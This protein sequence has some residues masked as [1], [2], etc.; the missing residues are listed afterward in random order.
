MGLQAIEAA[1]K[2]GSSV[3]LV[4]QVTGDMTTAH[5]VVRQGVSFQREGTT[6]AFSPTHWLPG[7]KTVE[8]SRRTSRVVARGFVAVGVC[9]LSLFIGAVGNKGLCGEAN[10]RAQAFVAPTEKERKIVQ[11]NAMRAESSPVSRV[12][13]TTVVEQKQILE[14]GREKID[15]LADRLT[16][17]QRLD[18]PQG[19]AAQAPKSAPAWARK[20]ALEHEQEWDRAEVLAPALTSSLRGE[21]DAL[22]SAAEAARIK[23]RQALKQELKQERDKAEAV[24]RELTSLRADLDAARIAGPEAAKAAAAAV[25][26]QQALKQELKQERDKAEAVARELTSLRAD[27]DAARIA[28]PKAAKAAAAAVEQQQALKQ[29]LKQER[30]KAEAV[31]RE[32]TSLRADLDAARIAGPK[33]AKAAAAAVEQ[34]QALKQELKQE[35]D[36]AE[37]VSRELTSLRADLDAA[38]IA[39]PKAA[40]AAAAAVEQ[41]QALKQELKQERDKA[42]VVSRELTSLRAE[43][44]TARA[45]G[46]ETARTAEAVK[47][48]QKLAFGKERDKAETLARELASARKEAEERSARL[49]AAHAEVLQVIETS[50]ATAAEQKL[51]LAR[52]RDRADALARELTSVRNELEA[53]NRQIA[54][55]NALGALRS[56]EPVVDSAREWMAEHPSRTIAGKGRLPEQISGEAT[57]STSGRSSASKLPRP[58]AQLTAREAAPDSDPKVVMATE[59]S[60]S[61]GAASHSPV[62]EQRLLARANALLRQ[63]DIS[64]ARPLLEHALERG[65]ARAAFMLAETYDARVLQS[66]RARGISGDPTKARELY[67]RAQAGGIEDA[68]ERIE[69]LK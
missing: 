40:K 68:K 39:G 34:Q 11:P 15:I 23:Q 48:E 27:L 36:K 21:L 59:R 9:V 24:A 41:Q 55:L 47:I 31:A 67:A 56:R 42:E 17:I 49:A 22:R 20:Q 5:W 54:A 38:R 14:L 6:I 57:A 50:S 66:W 35:R 62:D 51:A 8:G 58:E 63:A 3:F 10:T 7:S 64:G 52:E 30:D 12:V 29:E 32:L 13:E 37:A 44:D 61:A 65:S 25:E 4:D 69:A 45:S 43:L 19:K 1:P 18:A 33:A 2:D 28:G 26:Q 53:G 60:V 46:L 16:P